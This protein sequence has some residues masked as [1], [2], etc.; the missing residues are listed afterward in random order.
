M[1][2]KKEKKKKERA[3]NHTIL[4]KKNIA[5]NA[6]KKEKEKKKSN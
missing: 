1:L 3:I 4:Y 2:A 6:C 5:L